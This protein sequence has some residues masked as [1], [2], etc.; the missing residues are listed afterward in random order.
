MDVTQA[1][2]RL[3]AFMG[4]YDTLTFSV[5]DYP[6]GEWI[7][8]CREIPAILTGGMNEA[9]PERIEKMQDAIITAAGIPAGHAN[10]LKLSGYQ[11]NEEAQQELGRSFNSM[12]TYVLQPERSLQVC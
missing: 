12:A 2:N 1:R 5:S 4:E 10:V 11:F 7:A 6:S 3:K 8:E 9:A